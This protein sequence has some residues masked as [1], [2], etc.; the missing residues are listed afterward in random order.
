MAIILLLIYAVFALISSFQ[1]ASFF[2]G[3][4]GIAGNDEFWNTGNFWAWI[5]MFIIISVVCFL[6]RLIS[7]AVNRLIFA[8]AGT[9]NNGFGVFLIVALIGTWIIGSI[10]GG[11]NLFNWFASFPELTDWFTHGNWIGCILLIIGVWG[12]IARDKVNND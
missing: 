6:I 2:I 8:I 3:Y 9:F 10:V 1:V 12:L 11:I 5:L 7:V 4:T